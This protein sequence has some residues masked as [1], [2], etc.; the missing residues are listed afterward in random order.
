M[1]QVRSLAQVEPTTSVP[2]FIPPSSRI[3]KKKAKEKTVTIS[4]DLP[5]VLQDPFLTLF[6]PRLR[7]AFG[8]TKAWEQPDVSVITALW[9]KC[10]PQQH[11]LTPLT[12]ETRLQDVVIKLVRDLETM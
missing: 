9:N 12:A 3:G 11:H 7:E 4:K 1:S 8:I 6:A 10:V 5:Q 2:D